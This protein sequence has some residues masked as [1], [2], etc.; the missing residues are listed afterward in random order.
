MLKQLLLKLAK[1]YL[2]PKVDFYPGDLVTP[3]LGGGAVYEVIG[4]YLSEDLSPVL[5]VRDRENQMYGTDPRIYK[6]YGGSVNI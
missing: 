4:V 3:E 6:K 1:K 5:F 2:L